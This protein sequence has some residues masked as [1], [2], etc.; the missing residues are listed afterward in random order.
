MM[1]PSPAPAG[2]PLL[3][4]LALAGALLGCGFPSLSG[5]KDD[6]GRDAQR[7][8]ARDPGDDLALDVRA[9]PPADRPGDQGDLA[10]E[11]PPPDRV[12]PVDRVTDVLPTCD[13]ADGAC[14]L[15]CLSD[16]DCIGN[17]GGEQCDPILGTCQV[18]LLGN[19]GGIDPGCPETAPACITTEMPRRCVFCFDDRGDTGSSPQAIRD[20]GCVITT[21]ICKP[22][23]P[24]C[25]TCE[26]D[27]HCFGTDALAPVCDAS[28]GTGGTC[29]ECRSSADC[30]QSPFGKHC[31]VAAGQ[32]AVCLSNADCPQSSDTPK[33]SRT[34]NLC[35]GCIVDGD[36]GSSSKCNAGRC[37]PTCVADAQCTS[38]DPAFPLCDPSTGFCSQCVDDTDCANTDR[39]ETGFGAGV[40]VGPSGFLPCVIDGDCPS[41]K[42]RCRLRAVSGEPTSACVDCLSGSDCDNDKFCNSQNSCQ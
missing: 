23:V 28:R 17:P 24:T 39:C 42:P 27:S 12:P 22:G 1:R 5:P 32:C 37:Q 20:S 21:P 38:F 19:R 2:G 7:D 9:D 18:C 10:P 11:G 29:V 35:L 15:P 25:I 31:D 16:N 4:A 41:S 34:A 14:G 30:V 33:C 36:C 8:Q 40:C 3:L 6:G 13:A 26:L